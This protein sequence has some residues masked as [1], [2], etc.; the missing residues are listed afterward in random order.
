MY[1]TT[2]PYCIAS[3]DNKFR[4]LANDS[5][6]ICETEETHEH[7]PEYKHKYYIDSLKLPLRCPLFFNEEDQKEE[8]KTCHYCE[9]RYELSIYNDLDYRTCQ[10]FSEWYW[11]QKSKR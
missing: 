11:K 5:H 7:C 9:G 2:C 1:D 10:I 6:D 3:L 4:C 8:N